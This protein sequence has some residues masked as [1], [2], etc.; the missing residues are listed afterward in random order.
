MGAFFCHFRTVVG[1]PIMWHIIA[2]VV[3]L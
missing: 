1:F 2:S 3:F